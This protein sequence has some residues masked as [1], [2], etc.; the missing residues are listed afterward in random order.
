MGADKKKNPSQAHML[1][2]CCEMQRV[3][4][5]PQLPKVVF[6][7][8]CFLFSGVVLRSFKHVFLLSSI[9]RSFCLCVFRAINAS[10]VLKP[11]F[12]FHFCFFGD[13]MGTPWGSV[14]GRFR[15]LVLVVLLVTLAAHTPFIVYPEKVH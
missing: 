11:F 6:R 14:F 3:P 15:V 5:E 2:A 10:H 9:L 12:A 4:R 13:G 7:S 8:F 1:S